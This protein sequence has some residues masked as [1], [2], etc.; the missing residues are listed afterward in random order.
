MYKKEYEDEEGKK[1]HMYKHT[2]TQRRVKRSVA[3]KRG[4]REV[5][6][7]WMWRCKKETNRVSQRSDY[8][9]VIQ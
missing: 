6:T 9:E 1:A 3:H 8:R 4:I 5:L 2:H 7:N